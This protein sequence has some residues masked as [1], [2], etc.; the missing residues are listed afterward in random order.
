MLIY[1]LINIKEKLK[2][3]EVCITF[4]DALKCQIDI[5]L[6]VL[7]DLKIK[8]F[9]FVYTSIFEDNPDTLEIFRHF[10]NNYF[11]SIDDFYKFF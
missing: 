7:E 6:Q 5:A 8:S 1:F 11:N 4:D 3:N 2:E 10:R 9:F